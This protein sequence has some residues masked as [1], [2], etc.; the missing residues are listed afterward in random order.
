[1]QEMDPGEFTRRNL[2]D[3]G[4]GNKGLCD[5]WGLKIKL[6]T[7]LLAD[8]LDA[9]SDV[10]SSVKAQMREILKDHSA[11]RKIF[12]VGSVPDLTWQT[13]WKDDMRRS[14]CNCVLFRY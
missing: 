7:Y 2:S 10:T 13:G 3:G 6:R 4:G 5:L 9:R 1:M 12:K 8:D 14:S 11:L